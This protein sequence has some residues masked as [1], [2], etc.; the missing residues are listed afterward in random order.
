M[1]QHAQPRVVSSVISRRDTR[2]RVDEF[3]TRFGTVVWMLFDAERADPVTGHPACIRQA[4][5]REAALAG[6]DF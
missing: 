4:D 3:L 6:I 2:Y 5:S 1:T